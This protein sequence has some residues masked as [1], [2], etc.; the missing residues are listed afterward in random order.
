MYALIEDEYFLYG[1]LAVM[2][3]IGIITIAIAVRSPTV[4]APEHEGAQRRKMH[5]DKS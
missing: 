4:E 3:V 5:G 1:L 2:I